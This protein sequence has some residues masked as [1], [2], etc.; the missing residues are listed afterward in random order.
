M[1]EQ[2]EQNQLNEEDRAA[3]TEEARRARLWATERQKVQ[4]QAAR[5][6][7]ARR[8]SS[9]TDQELERFKRENGFYD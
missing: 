1:T 9:M 5:D 2:T 3:L 7:E 6:A 8:I 4:D